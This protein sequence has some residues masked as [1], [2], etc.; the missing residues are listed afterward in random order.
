[1]VTVPAEFN[2]DRPQGSV[3]AVADSG[4]FIP[5]EVSYSASGAGYAVA[6]GVPIPDRFVPSPSA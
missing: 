5:V 6:V 2:P 3:V 1:M 4:T